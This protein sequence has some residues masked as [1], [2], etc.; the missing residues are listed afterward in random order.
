MK[1]LKMKMIIK[2][3]TQKVVCDFCESTIILNRNREYPTCISCKKH[4]CS[5]CGIGLTKYVK[6]DYGKYDGHTEKIGYICEKC[7]NK[8]IISK[9]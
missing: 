6:S 8:K 3:T 5:K 1:N 7:F 2:Q 9:K 4:V